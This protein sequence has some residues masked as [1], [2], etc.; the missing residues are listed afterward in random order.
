[1]ALYL[2]LAQ[3]SRTCPQDTAEGSEGSVFKLPITHR[4]GARV[5]SPARSKATRPLVGISNLTPPPQALLGLLSYLEKQ[6]V[7]RQAMVLR[8]DSAP[9]SGQ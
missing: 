9:N 2:P 4:L 5:S 7:L 8:Q 1:M 6:S 3:A